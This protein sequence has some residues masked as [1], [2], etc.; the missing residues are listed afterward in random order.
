MFKQLSR[1][2]ECMKKIQGDILEME[3]K[4]CKMKIKMSGTDG[5]LGIAEEKN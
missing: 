1:D 5:R 2:M 4:V 3:I